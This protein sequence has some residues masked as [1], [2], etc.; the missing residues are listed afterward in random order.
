MEI[1]SK[2]CIQKRKRTS[3]TKRN[4]LAPQRGNSTYL[5][6][7]ALFAIAYGVSRQKPS[8]YQTLLYYCNVFASLSFSCLSVDVNIL[9]SRL[10]AVHAV[11]MGLLVLR[12]Q[13][14]LA[15]KAA[16]LLMFGRKRLQLYVS[17]IGLTTPNAQNK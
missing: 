10:A 5:E 2:R 1:H 7:L 6:K 9:M 17:S 16:L 14:R 4:R 12:A 11:V 8:N 13:K 15:E 3:Q